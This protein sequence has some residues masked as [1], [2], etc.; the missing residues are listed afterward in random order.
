MTCSR[1][2]HVTQTEAENSCTAA[3]VCE[4]EAEG[5]RW[6]EGRRARIGIH[7][8]HELLRVGERAVPC[9]ETHCTLLSLDFT[10]TQCHLAPLPMRGTRLNEL[11]E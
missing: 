6:E 2:E 5:G 11:I 3:T 9:R 1:R 7:M 8:T 4:K 10:I